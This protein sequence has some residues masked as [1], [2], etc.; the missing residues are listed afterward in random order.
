MSH[1][2]YH[3]SNAPVQWFWQ[4]GAG[5]PFAQDASP[6]AGVAPYAF[7]SLA[8]LLMFFEITRTGF[9]QPYALKGASPNLVVAVWPG[10]Q[11]NQVNAFML[12]MAPQH[13]SQYWYYLLNNFGCSP[14]LNVGPLISADEARQIGASYVGIGTAEEGVALYLP[15]RPNPR[16]KLIA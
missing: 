10:P 14:P 2:K 11:Q 4:R 16:A 6:S 3:D 13:T 1:H 15:G 7:R 8:D 9:G 12:Y 5:W